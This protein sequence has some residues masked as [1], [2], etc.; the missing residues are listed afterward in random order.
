[1]K[2]PVLKSSCSEKLF[3]KGTVMH[4]RCSGTNSENLWGM[5]L[6]Y[7][8]SCT[9]QYSQEDIFL[10]F[11]WHRC[12]PLNFAKLLRTSSLKNICERLLLAPGWRTTQKL[13]RRDL[14]H[15]PCLVY[16]NISVGSSFFFFYLRFLYAYLFWFLKLILQKENY[17]ENFGRF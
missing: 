14:L 3:W 11:L 10:E 2:I 6:N 16:I 4:N 9:S 13:N 15:L 7:R 17:M 12:F 5:P 8:Y 1:M